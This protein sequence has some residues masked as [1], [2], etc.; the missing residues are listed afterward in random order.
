[1]HGDRL[2]IIFFSMHCF[3]PIQAAA[4]L[5]QMIFLVVITVFVGQASDTISLNAVGLGVSLIN[6]FG[7]SLCQ[8][9]ASAIDTLGAQAYGSK[10]KPMVRVILGKRTSP[11]LEQQPC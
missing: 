11:C 5:L 9:L 6:V 7:T 8:G 10:N 4:M 3:L 1:M 2:F